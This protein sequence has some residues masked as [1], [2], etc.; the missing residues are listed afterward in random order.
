MGLAGQWDERFSFGPIKK[1][2]G[3]G[4]RGLILKITL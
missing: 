3:K 1:R 4:C 2:I